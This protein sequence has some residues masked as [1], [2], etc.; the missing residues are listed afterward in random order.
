[1]NTIGFDDGPFDQSFRGD[2]PLVGVVCARTRID[3]VLIGKVRR[4]GRDATRRIAELVS[5]SPFHVQAHAILLQGIAVGG[6]NVVDV[7]ALHEA[8][9]RPVL[10][11]VRR[12]PDLARIRRVLLEKV[13]GGARKWRLIERLGPPEPLDGVWVQRVGLDLSRA[14]QVLRASRLHGS[15]PEPLR[16]AHLIAGAVGRGTSK[17]GA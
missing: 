5:R 11:V 9:E 16:L 17:G 8:L 10:V 4:D 3:G 6:F 7:Q 1:M 12:P 15:F 14:R 2:V 13:P